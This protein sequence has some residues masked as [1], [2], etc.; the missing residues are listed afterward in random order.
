MSH[1]NYSSE[2]SGTTKLFK[3]LKAKHDADFAGPGSVLTAFLAQQGIDLGADDTDVD[4]AITAD[5]KF[6]AKEKEAEKLREVRDRLFN[7]V[8]DQYRGMVQFLKK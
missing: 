5:G 4:A 2:F 6:S 1:L 7:P 3:L 8:F